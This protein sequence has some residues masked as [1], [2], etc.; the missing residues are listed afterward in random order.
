MAEEKPKK[1]FYQRTWFFALIG[2]IVVRFL[3]PDSE[4]KEF[5]KLMR[6]GESAIESGN[7]ESA[8]SSANSALEIMPDSTKAASLNE[9]AEKELLKIGRTEKKQQKEKDYQEENEKEEDE[10][11]TIETTFLSSID[12]DA[13]E[14]KSMVII[15]EIFKDN[16][17]NPEEIVS[18]VE[19][20]EENK[21]LT[22][23]AKG[24]DGWSDKSIRFGFYE[25]TSSVFRE[26]S[27]DERIDEIEINITF[28]MKDTYG[29]ISNDIVMTTIITRSELDEINWDNFNTEKLHDVAQALILHPTFQVY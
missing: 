5:T 9:R 28:P 24:K 13:T 16:Y 3:L 26:L 7:Y 19:Y 25:D 18:N 22:A 20:N 2:I 29:N 8:L 14:G 23:T 17:T 27:K 10:Y 21:I 4:Q 15:Y 12:V 1:P 11:K 6:D